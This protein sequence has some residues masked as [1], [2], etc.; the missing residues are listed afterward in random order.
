MSAAAATTP[1]KVITFSFFFLKDTMVDD[2]NIRINVILDK[3]VEE[4]TWKY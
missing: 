1:M 3:K 4:K 2:T